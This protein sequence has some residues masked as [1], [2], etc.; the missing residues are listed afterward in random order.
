LTS[1][2]LVAAAV[3]FSLLV[4]GAAVVVLLADA[5]AAAVKTSTQQ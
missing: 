4:A 2:A 1:V 5:K 3:A